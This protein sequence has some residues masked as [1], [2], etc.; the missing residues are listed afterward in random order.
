MPSTII[1]SCIDVFKEALDKHE[2]LI[3]K[4]LY[5]KGGEGIIKID[6][7]DSKA[8]VKFKE[9]VK[10]YKSPVIIQEFLENV[11]LGDK[12]VFLIEGDPV[13]VINRIPKKGDFKANLHLG[14]E[15]K[16]TVLTDKEMEICRFL[17]SE[18]IKNKLFMVGIDLISEKLTEINVTSPTGITQID[19][20]YGFKLSEE[21]L[22]RI[23]KKI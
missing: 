22:E 10:K 16:K 14:G 23:L 19:E 8:S 12:R 1:S 7:K 9:V 15:A 17:K 18:L 4:P 21:I 13:G 6:L 20:L 3:V 11:K 2:S 5:N